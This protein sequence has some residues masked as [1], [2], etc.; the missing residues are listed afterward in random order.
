MAA[1]PPG[2][3][4]EKTRPTGPRN[5]LAHGHF[6]A[7]P[8]GAGGGLQLPRS[9]TRP[10]SL[11]GP[12]VK[13]PIQQ[14]SVFPTVKTPLRRMTTEECSGGCRSSNRPEHGI[15]GRNSGRITGQTATRTHKTQ[16]RRVLGGRSP[17]TRGRG[18]SEVTACGVRGTPGAG[19]PGC[20]P[21][22]GQGTPTL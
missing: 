2:V 21:P 9:P 15:L 17:G 18:W 12:Q 20:W 5:L 19:R 1:G 6:G 14:T 11:G 16:P 7:S 8:A 3:G 13:H 4:G 10:S 22:G